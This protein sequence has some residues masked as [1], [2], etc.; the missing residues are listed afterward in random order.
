MTEAKSTK[1]SNFIRDQ[2]ILTV[3]LVIAL[4]CRN[5]LVSSPK[6]PNDTTAESYSAATEVVASMK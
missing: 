4:L 6:S 5:S 2:F 1:P 3:I